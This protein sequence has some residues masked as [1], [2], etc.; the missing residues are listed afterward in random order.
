[1]YCFATDML[2]NRIILSFDN[3]GIPVLLILEIAN[4]ILW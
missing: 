1:M 3:K 2:N 4:G